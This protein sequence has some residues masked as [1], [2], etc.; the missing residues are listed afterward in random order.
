MQNE[1]L[2]S[3]YPADIHTTCHNRLDKLHIYTLSFLREGG[4]VFTHVPFPSGRVSRVHKN[5]QQYDMIDSDVCVC[6]CLVG[7][8]D[9]LAVGAS[10][11]PTHTSH[12]N[13][14]GELYGDRTIWCVR[15]PCDTHFTAE[16]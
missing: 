14:A 16:E 15:A 13:R 10:A 11:L 7:V 2:L 12:K 1:F 3:A 6:V 5:T 8:L 4:T 9:A